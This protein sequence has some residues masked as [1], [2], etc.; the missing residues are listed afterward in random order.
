MSFNLQ[1]EVAKAARKYS[2]PVPL[3]GSLVQHESGGNPTIRSGAGAIGL[4]QLMPGTAKSLGVDPLD[5]VQNLDG[6][7][8]YLSSQYKRFGK[9][10]L[11]LAAYNAGPG[12]V[13]QYGG[14]PPYRET[15]HYVRNIMASMS[16]A[17]PSMKQADTGPASYRGYSPN[18]PPKM[19]GG[20]KL[21]PGPVDQT[22]LFANSIGAIAR[23]EQPTST[24]RSLVW[25]ATHPAAPEQG[26]PDTSTV[27]PLPNWQSGQQA[28]AAPLPNATPGQMTPREISRWAVKLPGAD[29]AGVTTKQAVIDF[30][31]KIGERYGKQLQIGTGTNHHQYV[32]GTH[33]QS[34]HWTGDAA[35]IPMSG[36]ALT[37][38]GQDA[39]IAAGM[40]P[41][42]ARKQHG[43]AF[44]VGGYNILFNTNIGGNHYNHLHVGV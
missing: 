37:R 41:A 14:V 11:A 39:L 6:G 8:R 29:R 24:L 13:D 4:T 2:I 17:A 40:D 27:L 18:P 33:R 10:D 23:G 31:A 44:N 28:P 43:G 25:G 1:N 34:Q 16:A 15:R 3:F 20:V 22:N 7:A 9:W 32:L 30:V 21:G 19:P 12:A 42:E 35:D 5:P 38:L 26:L 36:T